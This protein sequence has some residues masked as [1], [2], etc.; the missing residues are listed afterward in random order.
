MSRTHRTRRAATGLCA[1]AVLAGSA[2]PTALA[3]PYTDGPPPRAQVPTLQQPAPRTII[4][5][6]R[7]NGFDVGDAAIGAGAGIG[8]VL[9]TVGGIGA[10]SHRRL[11]FIH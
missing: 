9:L 2:A 7:D 5:R 8:L 4:Q 11:R 6:V 3:R 1:A 10:S